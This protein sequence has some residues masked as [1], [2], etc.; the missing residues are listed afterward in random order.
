[1]LTGSIGMLPSASI[2]IDNKCLCE[3]VHGSAPDI[4]GQGI[5]NPIAM[6]LSFAMML[7]YSLDKKD[8]SKIIRTS[9][10]NILKNGIMTKDLSTTEDCVSTSQ[11]GDKILEEVKSNVN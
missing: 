10:S 11:L 8:L 7:E 5:V 9:V 4:A 1:M 3:P 6:I 2:S